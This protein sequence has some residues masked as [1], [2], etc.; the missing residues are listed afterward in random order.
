MCIC[1]SNIHLQYIKYYLGDNSRGC[2][3]VVCEAPE[4]WGEWCS[5]NPSESFA[6]SPRVLHKQRPRRPVIIPI[7]TR[8]LQILDISTENCAATWRRGH[9]VPGNLLSIVT[10]SEL[11]QLQS[12]G[13]Y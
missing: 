11:K 7:V 13:W 1:C 12:H 2:A 6:L 10:S 8:N 3:S 4:G 5:Q 9:L